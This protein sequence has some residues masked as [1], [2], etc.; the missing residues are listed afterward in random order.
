M[1]NTHFRFCRYGAGHI[2]KHIKL[3]R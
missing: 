2:N 1:Y 3:W